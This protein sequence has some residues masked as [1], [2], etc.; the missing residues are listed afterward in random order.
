VDCPAAVF[1]VIWVGHAP[2]GRSQMG[3]MMDVGKSKAKVYVQKNLAVKF[4]D[5]E[6][7]M[8]QGGAD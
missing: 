8:S 4:A 5:V 2:H 3:G 1:F 6:G 7:S